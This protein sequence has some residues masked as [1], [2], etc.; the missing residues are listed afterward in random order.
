VLSGRNEDASGVPRLVLSLWSD[1]A[2]ERPPRLLSKWALLP[3]WTQ[4]G[5]FST[6]P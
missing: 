6:C 2:A 3:P 1:A 5:R 4:S